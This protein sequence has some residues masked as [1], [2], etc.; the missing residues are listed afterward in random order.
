MRLTASRKEKKGGS[1]FECCEDAQG[2][3]KSPIHHNFDYNEYYPL[4]MEQKRLVV[5]NNMLSEPLWSL[6]TL[7]LLPEVDRTARPLDLSA[8]V[9]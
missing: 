6:L 2:D 8:R 7:C 3:C 9:V 4:I 5:N 1:E